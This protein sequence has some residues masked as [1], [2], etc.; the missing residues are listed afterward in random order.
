MDHLPRN[1]AR[2]RDR[3]HDD[4]L[5]DARETHRQAGRSLT[6][7]NSTFEKPYMEQHRQSELNHAVYDARYIRC[8]FHLLCFSTF[9]HI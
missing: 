3:G 9:N 6:R 7:Q 2:A 4:P 8:A 1:A 5:K